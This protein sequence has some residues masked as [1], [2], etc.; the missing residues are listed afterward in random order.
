MKGSGLPSWL[1]LSKLSV[2]S[3]VKWGRGGS[4][5]GGGEKG[6]HYRLANEW[7]RPVTTEAW[8]VPG[9]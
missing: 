3:S 2:F 4:R 1:C 6:Q 5:G 9:A 8:V 7:P